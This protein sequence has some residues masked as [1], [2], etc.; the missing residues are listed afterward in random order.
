M[1]WDVQLNKGGREKGEW[2]KEVI[3]QI[4]MSFL[5]NPNDADNKQPVIKWHIKGQ[6]LV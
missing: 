3:M 4:E 6:S 1:A 2:A 5:S